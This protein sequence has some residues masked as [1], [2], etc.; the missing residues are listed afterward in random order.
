MKVIPWRKMYVFGVTVMRENA[1]QN[2]S[3]YVHFLQ[4]EY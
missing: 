4:S 3:E 1:D 2:N